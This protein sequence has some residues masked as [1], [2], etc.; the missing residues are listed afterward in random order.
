MYS[1]VGILFVMRYMKVV[2]LTTKIIQIKSYTI[3]SSHQLG[4][5]VERPEQSTTFSFFAILH[6]KRT[7]CKT[8]GFFDDFF[9][10]PYTE[11]ERPA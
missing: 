1:F 7:E 3:C 11:A 4:L 9:Q 5:E 10:S 8:E 6:H 2:Y